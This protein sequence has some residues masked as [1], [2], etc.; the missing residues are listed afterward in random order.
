MKQIWPE[1]GEVSLPIMFCGCFSSPGT[2]QL[3][4]IREMMKSEGYIKI[5]DENLQLSAQNLDQG[6]WFTFQQDNYSK[7]TSKSVTA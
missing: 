6:R 4:A 5:L 2:R 7:H 3:I 1:K